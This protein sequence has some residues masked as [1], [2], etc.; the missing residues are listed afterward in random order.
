MVY[1]GPRMTPEEQQQHHEQWTNL[2]LAAGKV[3]TPTSPIDERSLFAGRDD[4]VRTIVDVINQKG[5]HAILYGERGVGKTSLANILSSFL[6]NPGASILAPRVNCDSTDTFDTVW[7]KVFDQISLTQAIKRVGFGSSPEQT[8]FVFTN[9]IGEKQITPDAVR[10][11]LTMLSQSATL[12]I[13]IVDEFDR[14]PQEPRRAFADTIKTLSDHS[15]NATVILVGVADSVGQ[16]I[17]EHQSV[18]RALV[19]V[20]MPRMSVQEIERIFVTGTAKLGMS[21]SPVA[22]KRL[23]KL[24]QGLPHYAHLL[25]LNASRAAIENRRKGVLADDVPAATK[26]AISAAQHSIRSAYDYAVRSPR[27][28]NLFSD[29]LLA[30]AMAETNELGFFAA[31]HVRDPMRRVTGKSYEIPSFAQH[32]NEFCE[33]KRGPILHKAGTRRRFRYR[34]I[35]P[36]LQPF[37]IMRGLDEKKINADALD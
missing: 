37:I 20:Q 6:V 26:R 25:G 10:R 32:L 24:A 2:A 31:Q 21:V 12:P 7:R 27:K 11:A 8:N 9:A 16:L 4:Q 22:L 34:F 3:F 33:S 1:T 29:V 5:Q 17:E 18:Q 30:C 19:Q 13:L 35:D 14:L 28:D 23:S 36:L 15:V